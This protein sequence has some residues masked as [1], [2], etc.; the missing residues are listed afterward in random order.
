ME[1]VQELLVIYD[2]CMIHIE[3]IS[4]SCELL[5]GQI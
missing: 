3:D 5:N 4:K 1:E 2:I